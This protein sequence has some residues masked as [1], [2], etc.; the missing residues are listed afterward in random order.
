[1]NR[2]RLTSCIDRRT[3]LKLG[4][5]GLA[6]LAGGMPA[7]GG[8]EE[9]AAHPDLVY[10]TLG[11]TGLKITTVSLGAMRTSEPAVMQAAF[12]RGVN[13]VDTARGYMD[14]KNE[15]IVGQAIKGRRDK[16]YVATKFSAPGNREA[17]LKSVE[18]SLKALDTDYIDV[19]QLHMPAPKDAV[20]S[21]TKEVLAELKKQGKIRFA[22]VTTHSEQ[23]A[24]IDAVIADPDK[25]YD[26]V[27]VAY[28]FKSPPE[29]K[30]AIA[31]AATAGLG[32]I[33]MKTQQGGY[34]TK[35]LGDIS[36]HQA[37]LKWVLQDTNIHAA[38]PAMVDLQQVQEDIDVMKQMKLSR[39]E[40]QVLE[41][42]AD[43]IK[44][45]Y[46]HRCGSCKDTCPKGVDMQTVNRCLM[47][48]EG[49]RDM[50]L[51][52]ETYAGLAARVSPAA[53]TDCTTC[54]AR[55]AKGLDLEERLSKARILFA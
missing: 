24:V 27:L 43:A 42:Y 37:A 6:A 18:T 44:P 35:E 7:I 11:R 5:A 1:M 21:E 36:P 54:T 8:A 51:A 47:Y 22:G 25:F 9:V 26:M 28:N 19:Y 49:Y 4:P 55:C 40:L 45:Y 41:R 53:C 38:V 15:G 30:Q 29:H 31:R 13:Y 33:A 3:F 50:A 32:V 10:R 14:G 17:V 39:A 2:N 16:V 48:A 52:R 20:R 12:D 34:E 46:C 23:V